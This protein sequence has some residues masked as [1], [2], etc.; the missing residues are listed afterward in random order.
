MYSL[1][2]LAFQSFWN[3]TLLCHYLK[4]FSSKNILLLTCQRY[5]LLFFAFP[6][7]SPCLLNY[8]QDI[9]VPNCRPS[10]LMPPSVHCMPKMCTKG[11]KFC[12]WASIL[13]LLVSI[14]QPKHAYNKTQI[15]SLCIIDLFY[16]DTPPSLHYMA[17]ACI[18]NRTQ[19]LCLSSNKMCMVILRLI[20]VGQVGSQEKKKQMVL[21]HCL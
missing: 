2:V 5:L 12:V 11:P 20:L 17:K 1:Q 19:N 15:L 13:C 16:K 14:T 8:F 6:L 21:L 7:V 3:Q 4:T 9:E 18:I 10:N